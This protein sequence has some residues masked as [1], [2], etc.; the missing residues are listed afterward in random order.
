MTDF[1]ATVNSISWVPTMHGLFGWPIETGEAETIRSMT[2]GDL[3]VPK[4]ARSPIYTGTRGHADYQRQICAAFDVDYDEQLAAYNAMVKHGQAAVPFLMRVVGLAKDV[5]CLPGTWTCVDIERITLTH[6]LSTTEFLKLRAL[7]VEMAMQFKGMAAPGRRI[8][9]LPAGTA[10]LVIEAGSTAMRGEEYLRTEALVRATTAEEA[11]ERLGDAGTPPRR[12]DRAFLVADDYVPGLHVCETDGSLTSAGEKIAVRPGGLVDL[13]ERAKVRAVKKDYFAARNALPPAQEL[14]SLMAGGDLVRAVEEFSSFHDHYVLLPQRVTQALALAKRDLPGNGL[15]G[16]DDEEQRED[17]E[18]GESGEQVES[19]KLSYLTVDAA[20]AR[21]PKGMRLPQSVLAEAVT[22]LRSGKHLLLSGPPGTGKSTVA[23]ALCR[24]VVESNFKVATAT[25]DWTTFDT[26]GGYVPRGGGDLS[27][28]AGI[29]LRCLR[30]GSW[31]IIDELNRADID[32]AFGPLFTLLAGSGGAVN[33]TVTLPYREAGKG[34]EIGWSATLTEAKA[35]Y[36]VT[37]VWRLIGTMNASDKA[38]L[39]QL[40]F[41]FLRRFAVVDVPLPDPADYRAFLDAQLANDIPKP[42][43]GQIVDAAM[44]IAFGP[45]R[46]GPAILKDIAQFTST[47]LEVVSGG[48]APFDDPVDAFL[49]A[50]RLYAVPQYEGAS[51]VDTDA[52]L[53]LLSGVWP[54]PPDRAWRALHEAVG[55]VALA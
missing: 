50:A 12:L 16:G 22:A 26:I 8:Q 28:E 31:L 5:E 41:A 24:A 38:S 47:G 34:I 40:S 20:Q 54:N 48:S 39:F 42:A 3:I 15:D 10:D 35:A 17:D 53:G 30:S 43:R 19:D 4:Y 29:V 46:L 33:D 37:P 9:K 32:K 55:S 11:V 44:G 25:A 21:L 49:T 7:P 51:S 18:D 27:F 14:A 13:F 23:G 6:P 52:F 36:T 1:A 45:V 2:V